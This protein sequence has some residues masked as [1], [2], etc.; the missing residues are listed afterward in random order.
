MQRVT[1]IRDYGDLLDLANEL[2]LLP[3]G[4]RK[5]CQCH[6]LTKASLHRWQHKKR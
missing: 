1:Q 6:S 3:K 5:A 4:R 2:S